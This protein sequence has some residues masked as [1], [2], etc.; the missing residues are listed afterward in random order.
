MKL[1]K[2]LV[3]PQAHPL[4]AHPLAAHPLARHQ[5][6]VLDLCK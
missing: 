1:K 4:A 5:V 6:L 3:H 2:K